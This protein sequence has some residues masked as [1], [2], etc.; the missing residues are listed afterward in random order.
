MKKSLVV[1]VLVVALV[2]FA[3]GTCVYADHSEKE[4]AADATV[5]SLSCPKCSG[6]MQSGVTLDYW[7]VNSSEQA[8]WSAALQKN[9]PFA[10]QPKSKKII[11]YRCTQCGYLESYAK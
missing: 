8:L 7:N 3:A 4:V 2:G 9:F 1:P 5:T 6:A 11:T 10:R